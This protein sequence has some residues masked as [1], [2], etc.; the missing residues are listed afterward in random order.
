MVASIILSVGVPSYLDMVR[1][2]RVATNANE[3]ATAF[4]IARSEAIRRGAAVTVCRSS[5]SLSCG[6]AWTDGWIVFV[7]EAAT[8]AAPP[9][10]GQVLNVWG[11]TAGSATL[12]PRSNGA[13]TDLTWI[14]FL[15]R[16]DTRTTEALPITFFLEIEHC[17]GNAARNIE[18]NAV[19]R[20]RV[21]RTVCT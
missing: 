18:V 15:A 13:D 9:A 3:L 4:A 19:G 20:T 17:N 10:V 7:D 5:D 14:R 1:G 21:E 8:E 16:G 6:G 2:T 12:V 11:A